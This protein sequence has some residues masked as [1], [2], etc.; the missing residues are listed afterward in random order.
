[1]EKLKKY[2]DAFAKIKGIYIFVFVTYIL[3]SRIVPLVNFISQDLNSVIY[4]ALAITGAV[5]V[6]FDFFM[7]FSIFKS[8]ENIILLVF[9]VICLIS[10]LLNMKYG[11]VNNVKTLVWMA[12]Q[13][14]L[15]FSFVNTKDK[16]INKT[17]KLIMNSSAAI[18]LAGVIASL[19]EFFLQI[20]YI[21]PASDFPRRQGF[22]EARLF[23]VFTDPN[24]AAL[25]SML[26]IVFCLFLI[27]Y[28][29]SKK[30]RIYYWVN[31]A[32]QLIYIVL[33]GSR[34]AMLEG[35]MLVFFTAIVQARNAAIKKG[36]GSRALLSIARGVLAVAVSIALVFAV[37]KTMPF[38]A[39]LCAPLRDSITI[40]ID[41]DINEEDIISLE[42]HDVNEENIS[43]NRFSIWKSAI[44]VSQ[45]KRIFGVS[46]RNLLSYAT[47]EFPDSYLVR[48]DYETHNGYLALFVN[49][50]IMGTLAML[51]LI[52][53]VIRLIC[54]Y[55][56]C[57]KK[58][59]YD[60]EVIM[61]FS[62][63][64]IIAGSAIFQPEIFFVN[65]YGAAIFWLCLGYFM[66]FL[67]KK[68]EA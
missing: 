28:C 8:R 49:S 55:L 15:F 54:R 63:L 39:E 52:V 27:K 13:F 41:E 7:S 36:Q 57:K 42:R 31:I 17:L 29:D 5:L 58:Q 38:L 1:M 19:V 18:W 48:M 3:L 45:G 51:V 44:E 50:G 59:E 30:L 9:W 4:S 16:E 62:V 12:I 32:F 68:T 14:F 65:S 11:I 40:E 2:E 53:D 35:Y 43:N 20:S 64:F 67:K 47:E 60:S 6:A 24:F 25:T 37:Q 21:A 33:S 46:P 34:T 22:T 66:Y 10:S 61:L 56:K 23:G 26:V